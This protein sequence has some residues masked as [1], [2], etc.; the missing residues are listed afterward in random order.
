M[1][2]AHT[3]NEHGER[4]GEKALGRHN[5]RGSGPFVGPLGIFDYDDPVSIRARKY[6]TGTHV[7]LE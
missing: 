3:K 5:G 2:T 4:A 1:F 6:T 7:L